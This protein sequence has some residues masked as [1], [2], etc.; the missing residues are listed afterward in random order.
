MK[1]LLLIIAITFTT[2]SHAEFYKCLDKNK[3]I[4]YQDQP[5]ISEKDKL[6]TY[7]A[8]GQYRNRS[9]EAIQKE[10]S[11]LQYEV[12]R[13]SSRGYGYYGQESNELLDSQRRKEAESQ[14][15]WDSIGGR[16][17]AY[18]NGGPNNYEYN[19]YRNR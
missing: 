11:E 19:R 3:K 2:S 4:Q 13:R 14:H 9:P 7:K 12:E 8:R 17:K 10:I 1:K 16:S 6:A 18:E 5:C 15:R